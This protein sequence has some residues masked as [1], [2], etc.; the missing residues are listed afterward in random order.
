MRQLESAFHK[1]LQKQLVD[2]QHSAINERMIPSHQSIPEDSMSKE[3][4]VK[5]EPR[6]TNLYIEID[7]VLLPNAFVPESVQVQLESF[8]NNNHTI[9]LK[10]EGKTQ[11]F[12]KYKAPSDK[13]SVYSF[14]EGLIT[15]QVNFLVTVNE[16]GRNNSRPNLY[17][18]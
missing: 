2:T 8:E 6:S 3:S 11:R 1:G 17:S 10:Y 4:S 7:Y 5:P 12:I 9:P 15:K 13:S 14:D 16:Q 18:K